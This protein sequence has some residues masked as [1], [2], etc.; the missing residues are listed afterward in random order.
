M[1]LISIISVSCIAFIA[2]SSFRIDS[3]I[4]LKVKCSSKTLKKSLLITFDDG[5]DAGN[6]PEILD[7]LEKHHVK[8]LF[9]VE[10]FQAEKNPDLLKMMSEKGHLI[11]NHSYS[12]SNF[13][14][15][16]FKSTILSELEN[17]S[18][19]IENI[20]GKKIVYFRPPFGVTNPGI[21]YA[22]GKLNYITVGW[23]VRSKDT[24]LK[25]RNKIFLRVKDKIR[26]GD[27]LLFHDTIKATVE[28]LDELIVYCKKEGYSFTDPEK[29]LTGD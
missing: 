13:F 11:G 8:A 27:I 24:V 29:F 22:A 12:H 25:E 28:M 19:I 4:F 15:F 7:I 5:P 18:E 2:W 14:P 17:T 10:G 1:L 9:F 20:I 26:G 16:F 21:A 23:S 6:T 3:Q